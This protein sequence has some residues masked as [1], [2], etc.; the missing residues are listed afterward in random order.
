MRSQTQI[1]L[2]NMVKESLQEALKANLPR[3]T[4]RD[5]LDSDVNFMAIMDADCISDAVWYAYK[6]MEWHGIDNPALPANALANVI[7]NWSP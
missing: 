1:D 4:R 5:W 6:V 2:D 7:D 3:S